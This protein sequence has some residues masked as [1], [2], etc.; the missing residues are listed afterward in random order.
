MIKHLGRCVVARRLFV[1]SALLAAGVA[2]RPAAAQPQ[3]LRNIYDV[4]LDDPGSG[5]EVLARLDDDRVVLAATDPEHGREPWVTDG[6]AAGTFRLGDLCPGTCDSAPQAAAAGSHVFLLVSPA[7]LPTD[8]ELWWTDGTVAGT[9]RLLG[10]VGTGTGLTAAGER[11][12]V[13][14]EDADGDAALWTSDGT[15]SGTRRLP[16]LVEPPTARVRFRGAVNGRLIFTARSGLDGASEAWSSDGTAAGTRRLH[17]DLAG[18]QVL[19]V[20][21]GAVFLQGAQPEPGHLVTQLWWTD[22]TPEGTELRAVLEGSLGIA[23]AVVG[24]GRVA[25]VTS[26]AGNTWHLWTSDGRSDGTVEVH[27]LDG[28]IYSPTPVGDRVFFFT[29]ENGCSHLWVSSASAA[30]GTRLH[31]FCEPEP[32][33]MVP[34][35]DGVTLLAPTIGERV[36]LWFSDGTAAGTRRAATLC[37]GSS[38]HGGAWIGGVFAPHGQPQVFVVISPHYGGDEGWFLY[39]SDGTAAGTRAVAEALPAS[40]PRE[41]F[42]AVGAGVLFS[43][44]DGVHGAEP[45]LTDGTV[46]GTALLANLAPAGRDGDSRPHGFLRGGDGFFFFARDAEGWGLW[47]SDG[48]SAGTRLL[49]HLPHMRPDEVQA[50]AE[51]LL[52]AGGRLYFRFNDGTSYGDF[53][54]AADLATG[55]LQSLTDLFDGLREPAQAVAVGG[56]VLVRVRDSLYVSDGTPAGSAR[57]DEWRPR[58]LAVLDGAALLAGTRHQDGE[59]DI[60]GLWRLDADLQG[61]VQLQEAAAAE[62]APFAIAAAEDRVFFSLRRRVGGRD[63]GELWL[64]DGSLGGTRTVRVFEDPFRPGYPSGYPY[65][66]TVSGPRVFFNVVLRGEPVLWVSDGT[67]AGTVPRLASV[68]LPAAPGVDVEVQQIVPFA[69]GALLVAEDALRGTE[70][71]RTGGA[72]ADT[73]LLADLWPGAE[74]SRPRALHVAG[75]DAWFVADDGSARHVWRTDGSAAGTLVAD[76]AAPPAEAL[77]APE[78][79]VLDDVVVYTASSLRS[80]EEL[81]LL[82]RDGLQPPPRPEPTVPPAPRGLRLGRR[83]DGDFRS[84]SWQDRA[85]D[86]LY[87]VV[88]V[89]TPEDTAF[90]TL[91]QVPANQQFA[92]FQSLPDGVPHTFRVRAVNAV[93]PSPPSEEVSAVPEVRRTTCPAAGDHLCLLGDRFFTEVFWRDPRSGSNGRGSGAGLAGSDRSGTFW[94]FRPSNVELIVKVLDGTPVNRRY[95]VFAGGLTDV[96]YWLHV[97]DTADGSQQVYHHASGDLCGLADTTAFS[98]S[99]PSSASASHA[100]EASGGDELGLVGDR[101]RIEVEWKDQRSGDSGVG[102]AVPGSDNTGYFWFFNAANVELVVKVL[103]GRPVNGHWWVFHGGLTDVEYTLRVTDT[104]DDEVRTYHRPPDNLCG[105]AD[106]TAF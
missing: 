96:E 11:A 8:R 78:L 18:G 73:E 100:G 45:W 37:N 27:T 79:V 86:E 17:P 56:R 57:L 53:L 33:R 25:F 101:F 24:G 72:S 42:T 51:P 9:E 14:A 35:G 62:E 58:A 61:A 88:E 87:Q 94:F 98:S 40:I 28:A 89:K 103:D 105:G 10:G 97:T 7:E 5:Y 64:S 16:L 70:L 6:T 4:P 34:F 99:A 69:D 65:R 2:A 81:W 23:E 80:G 66:L 52:V 19:P 93:G 50:V 59:P 21:G 36:D 44:S 74:S 104:V 22:G 41:S 90:R 39:A 95:W 43:A 12:Y 92:N 82:P 77:A 84:L 85:D 102:R 13:S 54:M 47:E 46:A 63:Q 30:T 26:G 29:F 20:P 48:S 60:Y 38:C 91:T 68:D 15:A 75:D 67:A 71:W 32:D 83:P 49:H 3:L 106:T 31:T 76:G 55:T 1:L